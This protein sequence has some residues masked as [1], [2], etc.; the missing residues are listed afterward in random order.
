MTALVKQYYPELHSFK[1]KYPLTTMKKSCFSAFNSFTKS[2]CLFSLVIMVYLVASS[3]KGN[4]NYASYH[5]PE[6]SA[7]SKAA[8]LKVYD[9]LMS[10]RCMNCHPA[11]DVPLVGEASEEHD[12]GVTRGKK[13]KGTYAKC[14][15]CHM[16]ENTPGLNMAPGVP[17][18][19]M[20][21]ENMKMVFQGKTPRQLAALLLDSA[22]NGNKTKTELLKHVAEDALVQY[23]WNPGEGRKTP[24][25]SHA[26][27][28]KQFELWINNGAYL[29]AE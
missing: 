1:N 6:D 7:I 22:T 8:F 17:T 25:L 16:D 23:G 4:S 29:P 9:V 26:D 21:P 3:F 19:Q 14:S 5:T 27:F 20:P 18:W 15:T 28:V 10:P 12:Q 11:G 2:I 13:G 24:P